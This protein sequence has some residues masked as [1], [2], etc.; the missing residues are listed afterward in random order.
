M[1]G[2]GVLLIVLALILSVVWKIPSLVDELSGRKAKRQINRMRKL[3][4]ATG[5]TNIS[6]TSD[7]YKSLSDRIST[8]DRNTQEMVNNDVSGTNL[9]KLIDNPYGMVGKRTL[10]KVSNATN[11]DNKADEVKTGFLGDV[12]ELETSDEVK[13]G[14]LQDATF[15]VDNHIDSSVENDSTALFEDS[16]SD[17]LTISIVKEESS[18]N[19]ELG[20]SSNEGC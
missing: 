2:G 9:S 16:S 15:D 14:F 13:T 12:N 7:F 11:V 19:F 3:S 17:S 4:I 5:S 8:G 6:D 10:E 1:I 20:G 18:I